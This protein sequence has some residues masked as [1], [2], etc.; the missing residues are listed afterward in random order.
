MRHNDVSGEQVE[1]RSPA[2]PGSIAAAFDSRT[3]Q[4][5]INP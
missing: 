1:S 2:L 4:T 3:D 5:P